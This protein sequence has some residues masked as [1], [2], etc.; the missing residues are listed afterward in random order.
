MLNLQFWCSV[1][2]YVTMLSKSM[3]LE[4]K[5]YG[6]DVQCQ[7]GEELLNKEFFSGDLTDLSSFYFFA[8]QFIQFNSFVA[9]E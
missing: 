7:V 8:L 2:R 9:M 1:F 6:I 5:Q 3:N 4:Y